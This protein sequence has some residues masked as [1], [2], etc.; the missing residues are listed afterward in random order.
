ML[1]KAAGYST[2]G[3]VKPS[4]QD[5]FLIKVANTS[6]GDVALVV[7]A[8]GM[9]GLSKGELA[10]A[11]VVR[12][13]DQWFE[14]KLPGY[15]E[16]MGSSVAGLERL[17][18]AQWNG[19]V[20]ELN[21]SILQYGKRNRLNLGTTFTAMLCVGSRYSIA[22]VGDS[23][24]YQISEGE[25]KQLTEDQ[26]LVQRELSAGRITEEEALVHPQRNVLLQC[27][28]ASREVMPQVVSGALNKG[29]AY[30][31]CSDGFRHEL[32]EEELSERF[33]PAVLAGLWNSS[34]E[35][36]PRYE[37]IET[38]IRECV[39][40]LETRGEK[41]NITAVVLSLEEGEGC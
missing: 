30:L 12:A 7:V 38:R 34:S 37:G 28:G 39:E 11:Q 35:D 22:H 9:G 3:A 32:T 10:S 33:A 6:L 4:N 36:L 1:F 21:I 31:L 24:V 19:L 23:R 14:N 8:D 27:V 13:M 18:E 26:T 29:A 17:V 16:A 25:A 20:Q 41:D 2:K 5:S 40:Q 15:L